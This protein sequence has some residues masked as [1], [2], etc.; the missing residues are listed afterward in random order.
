MVS[1]IPQ[2]WKVR[3]K[4]STDDI[5]SYSIVMHLTAAII[6]ST[7]GYLL[8]LYILCIESGIVAVL[9]LT[10]LIAICRDRRL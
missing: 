4:N 2:V 9:N 6:W 7:Y 3:T 1:N 10:I 5:H 8:G